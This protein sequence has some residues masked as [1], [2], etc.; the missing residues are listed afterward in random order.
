MRDDAAL[1]PALV[2]V[3]AA[4]DVVGAESEHAVDEPRELMGGGSDGLGGSEAGFQAAV[5]GPEGGSAVVKGTGGEPERGRRAAGRR[6]SPAAALLAA[7]ELA[8]G[9]EAEPGGEVLFRG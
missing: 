6:F 5:K 3:L 2:V 8:A 1:V 7:G 9:R 4:V